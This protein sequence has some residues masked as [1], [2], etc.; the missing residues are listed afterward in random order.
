[1][2]KEIATEYT[3]AISMFVQRIVISERK[4]YGEAT[5]SYYHRNEIGYDFDTIS[6]K[7]GILL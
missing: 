1:M 2:D 3:W 4:H 5:I 6:P 7:R